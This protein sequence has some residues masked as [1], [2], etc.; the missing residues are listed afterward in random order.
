MD[1]KTKTI[2]ILAIVIFFLALAVIFGIHLLYP[3]LEP[4]SWDM[5]KIFLCGFVCGA[6]PGLWV[7]R[8]IERAIKDHEEKDAEEKRR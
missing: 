7:G 6:L 4:V 2:G 3:V 5:I 1:D 8:K